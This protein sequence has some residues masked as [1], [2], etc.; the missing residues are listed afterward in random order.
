MHVPET[1][2]MSQPSRH[3][4]QIVQL[5]TILIVYS[6]CLSCITRRPYLLLLSALPH[7]FCLS[8]LFLCRTARLHVYFQS[9]SARLMLRTA[10]DDVPTCCTGAGQAAF[11]FSAAPVAMHREP[12]EESFFGMPG[13][14]IFGA[15]FQSKHLVALLA[16]T[17]FLG[18]KGF[19]LGMIVWVAYKLL[20]RKFLSFHWMLPPWHLQCNIHLQLATY[21]PSF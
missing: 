14:K 3:A 17:L 6:D 4:G 13:L 8:S 9:I 7:R 21:F 20:L 15:H 2:H 12:Q 18:W 16:A 5:P 10:S 19:G 11:N 1:P